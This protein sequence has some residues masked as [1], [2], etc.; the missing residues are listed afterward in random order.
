MV[1][2][3]TCRLYSDLPTRTVAPVTPVTHIHPCTGTQIAFS[4]PLSFFNLEKTKMITEV[5]HVG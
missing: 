2:G 3:E 5:Y 4:P 1:E